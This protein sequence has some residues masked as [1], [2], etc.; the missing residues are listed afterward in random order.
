MKYTV[1]L[2]KRAHMKASVEVEANSPDEARRKVQELHSHAAT[3]IQDASDGKPAESIYDL[4]WDY[5]EL[6]QTDELEV[7]TPQE[8]A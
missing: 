5:V 6:D 1:K 2:T 7:H 8:K 4:K 3:G